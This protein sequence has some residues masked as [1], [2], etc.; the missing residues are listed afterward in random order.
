MESVINHAPSTNAAT[1][2][3]EGK[4]LAKPLTI[5]DDTMR[6]EYDENRF[7]HYRECMEDMAREMGRMGPHVMWCASQIARALA[8]CEMHGRTPLTARTM[9]SIAVA[10]RIGVATEGIGRDFQRELCDRAMRLYI[11]EAGDD[12]ED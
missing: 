1:A 9:A 5:G 4:P 10:G 7:E 2:I 6:Y 3:V 12:A 11:E 8:D